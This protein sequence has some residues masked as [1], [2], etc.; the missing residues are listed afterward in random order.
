VRDDS[1]KTERQEMSEKR[2]VEREERYR[3]DR[4]CGVTFADLNANAYAMLQNKQFWPEQFQDVTLEE[5][6]QSDFFCLI[7]DLTTFACLNLIRRKNGL[8]P[9][10]ELHPLQRLADQAE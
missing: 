9:L 4:V 3:K 1:H 6:L 2:S 5:L 7:V 10:T 8:E